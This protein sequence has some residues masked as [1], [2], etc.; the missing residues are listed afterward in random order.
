M[1]TVSP[2]LEGNWI[3]HLSLCNQQNEE[4][5]TEVGAGNLVLVS[6]VVE[7]CHIWKSGG[8]PGEHGCGDWGGEHGKYWAI[9][10]LS[11]SSGHVKM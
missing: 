10:R 5:K 11:S 9:I 4:M 6:G 1:N 8:E 2:S 7:C 3:C